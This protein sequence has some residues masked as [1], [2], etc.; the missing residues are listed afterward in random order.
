MDPDL[1]ATDFFDIHHA[2][3]DANSKTTAV[4]E[5][6]SPNPSWDG[7]SPTP[8]QTNL[9]AAEHRA[10]TDVL[11]RQCVREQGGDSGISESQASTQRAAP[12]AASE[13]RPE[14]SGDEAPQLSEC[15][16]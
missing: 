16:R 14:Q 15:R 10:H 2:D 11:I 4:R 13:V 9:G 8:I 12:A 3:A 5:I 6:E 1:V 7:Y